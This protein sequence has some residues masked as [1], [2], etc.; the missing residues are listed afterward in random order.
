MKIVLAS[1][2]KGKLAELQRMTDIEGMEFITAHEAGLSEDFDV[3]ETG[4][5][6]EENAVLK[7]REYAQATGLYAVADDSGLEVEA[8]NGAPG[9]YSKRYA[10]ENATDAY[11]IAFLLEKLKDVP[12]EKRAAHF[13]ATLALAAP[14]GTILATRTGYCPG[15]ITFTPRGSNGFGYD[16]IFVVDGTGKTMAELGDAEKDA[17]SHRGNA[18]RLLRPDL[19][20]LAGQE[21]LQS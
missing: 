3:E 19:L 13:V 16:P 9:V 8:L 18:L 7:A 14:D 2:N 10:G 17:V 11:R 21:G 1:N 15:Q 20:K 4:A 6:I 12:A 5:T